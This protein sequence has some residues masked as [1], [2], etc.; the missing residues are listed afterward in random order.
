MREWS[1]TLMRGGLEQDV[2]RAILETLELGRVGVS[3]VAV[4]VDPPEYLFVSAGS[5]Q[6]LGYTVEELIQIP[7]WNL[8]STEEVPELRARRKER[9]GESTGTRRF[10]LHLMHR[11]GQKIPVEV[12][13]SRVTVGGRP[14]NVSFTRDVST[15]AAALRALE[16]SE[17]RFRTLVES[18]PD[19]VVILRGLTLSYLNS[20]AAAMLGFDRPEEAIGASITTLLGRTDAARAESRIAHIQRTQ[21]RF[22]ESAEYRSRRRD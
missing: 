5:A 22:A 10:H 14:A 13:S 11:S 18:A 9:L 2:L 8:F 7:I 17:A 15:Q 3:I 4:D 19:G 16:A 12:T 1:D 20:A 21:Q 6:M